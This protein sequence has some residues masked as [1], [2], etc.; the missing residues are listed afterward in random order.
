MIGRGTWTTT[1]RRAGGRKPR[2]RIVNGNLSDRLRALRR[3]FPNTSME[4]ARYLYASKKDLRKGGHSINLYMIVWS[5]DGRVS[6]HST[7]FEK[8]KLLTP[9]DWA[10]W[11]RDHAPEVLKNQVL[12][13]L[14]RTYGSIWNIDKIVGWSYREK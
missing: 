4:H 5:E 12:A 13:N 7:I 8:S 2:P 9:A 14:N 11:L 3:V 10:D 6:L 1:V